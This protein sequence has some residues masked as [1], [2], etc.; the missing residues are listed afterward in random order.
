[1]STLIAVVVLLVTLLAAVALL[2]SVDTSNTLAGS[3]AFKQAATQEAELAYKDMLSNQSSFSGSTGIGEANLGT[4]TWYFAS[5]QTV[6]S[7]GV[8][9]ALANGTAGKS[10]TM[11]SGTTDKVSYV[12][13][14]LCPQAGPP[15][16]VAPNQCLVPGATV[17]GGSTTGNQGGFTAGALA[18]YRLT[19]RI[20][21]PKG[22]TTFVQTMLH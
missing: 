1:M 6:D 10:V 7:R 13:E 21:G 5:L 4:P 11:P 20:V 8:P 19:I 17:T 9:T 22:A 15:L 3:I 2:R 14:R 18:G 16:T 12:V